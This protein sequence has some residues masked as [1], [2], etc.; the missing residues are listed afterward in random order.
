MGSQRETIVI[1][2][3][4]VVGVSIAYFTMKRLI[5][6]HPD[7]ESRPRVILLEQCE[8]GCS[9]SGKSGGFLARHWSDSTDTEQLARFSYDLHAKLAEEHDGASRWGY[10][11]VDTFSAEVDRIP[12]APAKQRKKVHQRTDS[13]SVV[14]SIEVIAPQTHRTSSVTMQEY[15]SSAATPGLQ[16]DSMQTSTHASISVPEIPSFKVVPP[17]TVPWLRTDVVTNLRQVG[18][19]ANTA[20]VDPLKLTRSLLAEAKSMGLETIRAKVI[21]VA[22]MGYRPPVIELSI[23]RHSTKPLDVLQIETPKT[24]SQTMMEMDE[25][26]GHT[27]VSKTKKPYVVLLDQEGLD[28]PADKIVVACGAWVTSCLRW[29][30]FRD[31]SASQVPIQGLRVH[32]L[33]AKPKS[34]IPAQAVF[35]EINGTVYNGEDAIEIYP[36]PDGSVFVCGEAL[37]DPEMPPHNPFEPVYSKRATSRL[38]Q[39][40]NDVS[41]ALSFDVIQY[42]LACHLPVHAKGI[43]VISKVPS[44]KGLYIAAGHGCW[45][46]LNGPATG[47]A[48]SELLIDGKCSSLDL[49]NFKLDRWY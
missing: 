43:P 10:R 4:G 2:G 16:E 9:A 44:S 40:V 14:T 6:E 42:G 5:S 26:K 37:D 38:K 28:I 20:Q 8:P 23:D 24:T 19:T 36:R 35:A 18:V 31:V 29:E 41:T 12:V 11:P 1:I 45:G 49:Q 21:D 46:I 13:E 17:E 3:A 32:Y 15:S 34:E 27:K 7:P 47:L 48:I 22:E 30:A 33:L 25:R 39:I